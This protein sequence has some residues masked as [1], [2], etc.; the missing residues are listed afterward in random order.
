VSYQTNDPNAD[1]NGSLPGTWTRQQVVH[2]DG[3]AR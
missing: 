1:P 2:G 3:S